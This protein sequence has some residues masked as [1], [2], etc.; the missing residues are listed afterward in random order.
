MKNH[1][2]ILFLTTIVFSVTCCQKTELKEDTPEC[3]SQKINEY[4]HSTASCETGKSVYRYNFQGTFVYVFN[5]GDC[6][7][8]MMS[9]VYDQ[10]CNVLCGLGGIA[11]NIMCNGD[12]FGK[13]ATNET[14]IW[15]D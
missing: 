15:E 11:G 10:E 6:G 4:K 13:N 9:T 12:D 2:L 8:D 14:L 5:P 7:A 1:I 3:I